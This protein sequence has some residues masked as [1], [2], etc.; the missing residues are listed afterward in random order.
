MFSPGS[1]L[2]HRNGPTPFTVIR[3]PVKFI[4]TIGFV[5]GVLWLI[6]RWIDKCKRLAPHDLPRN[7]VARNRGLSSD[8]YRSEEH[9]SE[10]QS[11]VISYA[12]F[13]LKKKKNNFYISLF[14][15]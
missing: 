3:R 6:S 2:P 5:D 4:V 7:G 15:H 10:L 12:V 11:H 8:F 13:C 1:E 9:T 14:Y